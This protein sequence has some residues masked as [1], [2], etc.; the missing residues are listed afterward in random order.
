MKL[1]KSCEMINRE[2]VIVHTAH[3][4]QTNRQVFD[5]CTADLLFEVFKHRYIRIDCLWSSSQ[6][7]LGKISFENRSVARGGGQKFM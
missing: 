5:H 6:L 1:Q 4:S 7:V 3:Q 2:D